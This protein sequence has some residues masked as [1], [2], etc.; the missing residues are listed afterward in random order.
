MSAMNTDAFESAT[1]SRFAAHARSDSD[2]ELAKLFQDSADVD[3]TDNF[4]R[5]AA[6]EGLVEDSPENLRNAIDAETEELKM[7]RQFAIEAKADDDHA[8]AAAFDKMCA[9]KTARCAKLK[10][11]LADMG[12][13]SHIRIVEA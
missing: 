3:R 12:I 8:V 9:D 5:E 4:A 11:V 7:Y 6:L 10:A 13:H 2:W 1:Y